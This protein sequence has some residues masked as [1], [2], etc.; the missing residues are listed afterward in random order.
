[1]IGLWQRTRGYRAVLVYAFSGVA[2]LILGQPMLGSGLVLFATGTFVDVP[3][4]RP[5]AHLMP[6]L[7]KALRNYGGMLAFLVGMALITVAVFIDV[8]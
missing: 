8:L 3:L 2:A 7:E 6:G 4:Q 5:D 1:M